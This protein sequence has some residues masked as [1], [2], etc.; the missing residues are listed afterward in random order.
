MLPTG[1]LLPP[2][3]PSC[4]LLLPPCLPPSQS[5]PCISSLT[6]AAPDQGPF[7]TLHHPPS[8]PSTT[9]ASQSSSPGASRP[10]QCRKRPRPAQSH[11]RGV[12]VCGCIGGG[13]PGQSW[14][15]GGARRLH[16]GEGPGDWPETYLALGGGRRAQ[17]CP[18]EKEQ[19]HKS[20]GQNN[21]SAGG[22]GQLC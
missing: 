9:P 15:Q 8:P 11:G 7:S 22:V 2:P 19:C 6:L 4:F 17:G 5:C 1:W 18:E 12:G 14:V 16:G 3:L 10:A 20:P 21:L 13:R